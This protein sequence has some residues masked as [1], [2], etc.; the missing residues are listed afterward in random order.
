[1]S[2]DRE[3]PIAPGIT[4]GPSR[5][6]EP[7]AALLARAAARGRVP[8]SVCGEMA[9]NP[10]AVPILVGLGIEEL[11][12]VASAVPVVKEIVR[13]LDVDAVTVSVDGEAADAEG[14]RLD[15]GGLARLTASCLQRRLGRS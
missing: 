2:P 15:P 3:P 9:S 1:M 10:L 13:A 7:L 5:P 11:S 8:V 4:P 6:R 14:E 12:G